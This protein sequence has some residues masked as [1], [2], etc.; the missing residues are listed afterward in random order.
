MHTHTSELLQ[1]THKG[2]QMAI[3]SFEEVL[4]AALSDSLKTILQNSLE[5]HLLLKKRLETALCLA[6]ESPKSPNPLIEVISWL[7][8]NWKVSVG[9]TDAEIAKLM[10]DGCNMG[11]QS[12]A[13]HLNDLISANIESHS[14]ATQ[15]IKIEEDLSIALRPYL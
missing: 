3:N 12:L 2:I 5:Q 7:T 8:I 10:T 6:S 9:D 4:P 15:L 14:L 1:E 11:I 13:A